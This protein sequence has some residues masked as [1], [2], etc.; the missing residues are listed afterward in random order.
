MST[1]QLKVMNGEIFSI[2]Y[3][4]DFYHNSVNVTIKQKGTN[5][6]DYY[7]NEMVLGFFAPY[8]EEDKL[9]S[10]EMYELRDYVLKTK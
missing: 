3:L 7:T 8:F 9:D 1:T 4:S 10:P 2:K 6:K 5:K